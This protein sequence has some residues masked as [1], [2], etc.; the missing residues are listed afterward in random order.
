M[1]MMP[2][3]KQIRIQRKQNKNRM[4]GQTF[5]PSGITSEMIRIRE[6]GFIIEMK[7]KTIDERKAYWD[8]VKIMIDERK[9]NFIHCSWPW[10]WC[11]FERHFVHNNE[12]VL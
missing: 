4:V 2:I 8:N 7:A 1:K 9:A 5:N 10:Q 11:A 6:N 12:V 3:A